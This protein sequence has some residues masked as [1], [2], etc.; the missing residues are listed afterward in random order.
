MMMMMMVMMVMP[1]VVREVTRSF[2]WRFKETVRSVDVLLYL[3]MVRYS[4]YLS[5]RLLKTEG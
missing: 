1:S 2:P 4:S 3:P 5:C